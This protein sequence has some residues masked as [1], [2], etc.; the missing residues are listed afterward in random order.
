MRQRVPG[1]R[2]V[3]QLEL[4]GV[5][6]RDA[7]QAVPAPAADCLLQQRPQVR[8]PPL[9]VPALHPERAEAHAQRPEHGPVAG[10]VDAAVDQGH[11][12]RIPRDGRSPQRTR[13]YTEQTQVSVPPPCPSV[14]SVVKSSP[15]AVKNETGPGQAPGRSKCGREESNLHGILL[16]LGPEPSASANSATSAAGQARLSPAQ[17]PRQPGGSVSPRVPRRGPP[18]R[19]PAGPS[20]GWAAACR[21]SSRGSRRPDR[22]SRAGTAWRSRAPGRRGPRRS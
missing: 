8:G 4:L 18:P 12:A 15:S 5:R 16:P 22:G 13:R 7:A 19:G 10:L 2:V 1:L 11:G 3:G 17:A 14:S 9:G 21:G 6:D 20:C